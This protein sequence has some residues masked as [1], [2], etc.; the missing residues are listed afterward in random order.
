MR[1]IY[2]IF[3]AFIVITSCAGKQTDINNQIEALNDTSLLK[4]K[5]YD[6]FVHSELGKYVSCILKGEASMLS[7]IEISQIDTTNS[8]IAEAFLINDWTTVK[9]LLEN[10]CPTTIDES[11]DEADTNP[12]LLNLMSMSDSLTEEEFKCIKLV[13]EHGVDLNHVCG[14]SNWTPLLRVCYSYSKGGYELAK[15]LIDKGADVNYAHYDYHYNRL[16]YPLCYA[17]ENKRYDLVELF[18]NRNAYPYSQSDYEFMKD[19]L[20]NIKDPALSSKLIPLLE[21]SYNER[22][23]LEK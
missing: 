16:C 22:Y 20:H 19:E 4:T 21:S 13:V 3:A 7:T 15:Y 5:G 18:L 10:G 9:I 8:I 23:K 1:I 14:I 6:K 11:F 2:I 17:F 12:N